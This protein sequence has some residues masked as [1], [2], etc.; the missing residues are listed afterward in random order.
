MVVD[1][2]PSPHDLSCLPWTLSN[3]SFIQHTI[4]IRGKSNLQLGG[5]IAY[6]TVQNKQDPLV[7]ALPSLIP[8][9]LHL[10]S[11]EEHVK[12]PIHK[13]KIKTKM[14]CLFVWVEALR[15][16]QQ[17]S[18][19]VGTEPPLPGYYQCYINGKNNNI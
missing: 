8:P 12:H 7:L 18:S 1:K 14:L 15:P 9:R 16:S 3:D 5:S 10:R 4:Q 13:L 17:F 2:C 6:T 19:H 11:L